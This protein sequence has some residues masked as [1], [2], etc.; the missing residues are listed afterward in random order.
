MLTHQEAAVNYQENL[1]E[2]EMEVLRLVAQGRTNREIAKTLVISQKTV[3][4]HLHAGYRK[5]EIAAL[6]GSARILAALKANL[7]VQADQDTGQR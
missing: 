3:R 1:T 2:R 5:L 7:L 4:R 6:G